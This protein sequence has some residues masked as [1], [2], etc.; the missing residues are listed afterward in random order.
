MPD[1]GGIN[2]M[3]HTEIL[4]YKTIDNFNFDVDSSQFDVVISGQVLEH[5]HKARVWMNELSRITKQIV[6]VITI[7][8]VS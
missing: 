4:N 8:P 1:W 3:E 6:Y 7:N 2:S 5:V